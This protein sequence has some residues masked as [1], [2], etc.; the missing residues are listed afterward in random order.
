MAEY[1][2]ECECSKEFLHTEDFKK[3]V[4][5]ILTFCKQDNSADY[6]DKKATAIAYA[7]LYKKD[8]PQEGVKC[9]VSDLKPGDK[10]LIKMYKGSGERYLEECSYL[11]INPYCEDMT[12]FIPATDPKRVM[13]LRQKHV[14]KLISY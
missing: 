14:I 1:I 3:W 2:G 11:G 4:E 5:Y 13:F 10:F 6:E 8:I 7:K 12:Y 9:K